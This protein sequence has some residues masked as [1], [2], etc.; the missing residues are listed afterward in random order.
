MLT[1]G[2]L[3]GKIFVGKA[4]ID[5]G[6]ERGMFIVALTQ[7]AAALE[8]NAHDLQVGRIHKIEKSKR[9]VLLIRGPGLAFKPEWNFGIA[10]HRK[11]AADEG[12]CFQTVNSFE[13]AKGFTIPG[14]QLIRGRGLIGTQGD[15]ERQHF[16]RIKSRIDAPEDSQAAD[17]QAR[18]DEQDESQGHFNSDQN[19]LG[20]VTFTARA[21]GAFLQRFNYVG[22]EHLQ[23]GDETEDDAGQD[24]N[25]HSKEKHVRVEAN[26]FDARQRI[27]QSGND[28]AHT[29]FGQEEAD[30]A[31]SNTE[32]DALGQQLANHARSAGTEG[33]ADGKFASA[34]S[35]AGEE[36]VSHVG[37]GD[38]KHEADRPQE[39][40]ED[41]A[42]IA[43]NISLKGNECYAGALVGIGI[44][45]SEVLRD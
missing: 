21:A 26:F 42:H 2:I 40:E 23:S 7:K 41:A 44:S 10:F 35:R 29:Q 27:R 32:Q 25:S 18:A 37:A 22:P 4:G 8:R 3:V 36:Q 30:G 15:A 14:A 39:D 5:D 11:R 19:A 38:E 28:G 20:S 6:D 9:H 24:G 13:L 45:G 17:H 33:G 16:A 1:D 34:A 12:Y 43:D 31:A